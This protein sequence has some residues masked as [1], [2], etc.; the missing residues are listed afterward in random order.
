MHVITPLNPAL[1]VGLGRDPVWAGSRC[2]S[3]SKFRLREP[4]EPYLTLIF[5]SASDGSAPKVVLKFLRTELQSP[6]GRIR[7]EFRNFAPK[8]MNLL[9][10]KIPS[11]AGKSLAKSRNF[12]RQKKNYAE[13]RVRTPDLPFR[14]LAYSR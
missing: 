11:R 7:S 6:D 12:G 13:T 4:D 1:G 10:Y 3:Q 9:E 2:V 5:R 14:S 8:P